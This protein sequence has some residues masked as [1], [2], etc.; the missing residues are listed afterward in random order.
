M[1]NVA[2]KRFIKDWSDAEERPS[3]L[4]ELLEQRKLA[5]A[6]MGQKFKDLG[7]EQRV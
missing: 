5:R 1:V 3:L 2:L 6:R 7:E 4:D